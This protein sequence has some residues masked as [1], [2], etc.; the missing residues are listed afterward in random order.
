M[1]HENIIY[2]GLPRTRTRNAAECDG[3]TRIFFQQLSDNLK[4]YLL[5]FGGRVFV[6]KFSE[7][8]TGELEKPAR[9]LFGSN[10]GISHSVPCEKFEKIILSRN[11]NKIGIRKI[12]FAAG[13]PHFVQSP[14]IRRNDRSGWKKTSALPVN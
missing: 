4:S 5:F 13:T 6:C 10:D 9:N 11:R 3:K 8:I 2:G 12:Q 1:G 14:R 7:I